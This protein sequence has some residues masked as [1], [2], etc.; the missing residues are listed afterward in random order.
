MSR[1]LE[2]EGASKTFGGIRAADAVDFSV[3]EGKIYGIIGPNG[4]GKTTLQPPEMRRL[5]QLEDENSKLKMLI[6]GEAAHQNEM[7]SP[8][9]TE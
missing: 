9:V 8:V 6:P 3:D 4:S 2:V 1:F 5:K 7:M